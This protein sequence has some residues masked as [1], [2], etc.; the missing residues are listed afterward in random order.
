MAGLGNLLHQNW[1]EKKKFAK[2]VT[3]QAIDACYELALQEGAWGG[4]ISGA[5]GGGF[6]LLCCPEAR[7]EAVTQALATQG[8]TR[9][10]FSIDHSGARVLMNSGLRLT[11]H[12]SWKPPLDLC[13]T[14]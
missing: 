9:V 2:G 8:L 3:N 1:L 7:Q 13:R 11:S 12:R 10:N 14:V 4:K 5:G 6:L